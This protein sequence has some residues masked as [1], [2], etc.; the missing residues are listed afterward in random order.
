MLIE[1]GHFGL[2]LALVLALLQVILPS[3]GLIRQNQSLSGMAKPLVWGQFFWLLVAFLV[4]TNAF[5]TNDFSVLYVANNSN[6]NLPIIYQISAV[7]GAHEGS[8]LLWALILATW[9]LAVSLLSKRLPPEVLT[10]VLIIFGIISIGFLSFLIF[11]SNPFER[12]FP[13][14]LQGTELNPLL[15]DFGLAIHPPMLYMGYVG[16]AVP[17]AFVLSA[18]I[19]GRLDSTWL[20]LSM[21]WTLI[22]WMFLTIGIT[23]G[24]WWAYYELGWGGWWFWDPVENASFM[25]WLVATALV[26][27]L[28]V[29]QKRDAFKHW[30]V[31]LAIGGFSLSL[32]GTFLVRS[33]I[34][35]SVHSFA[36]DPA[37]G[38]FILIFL[39]LVVGSSFALYAYRVPLMKSQ[40]KFALLSR[41]SGLLVNNIVLTVAMFTVLLGT[42]Y[43]LL[44]DALSLGKISVGAPYFSSVFIPIMIPGVVL[45]AVTPFL[46]WKADSALRVFGQLKRLWLMIAV[47][48]LL[49]GYWYLDNISVM[50]AGLLFTWVTMHS[51]L[52][53]VQKLKTKQ[54][55]SLSFL[56]MIVA[57]IGIAVFVL[58]A[59]ITTQFGIEKDVKLN[60][61]QQINLADYQFTFDGVSTFSQDNYQGYRGNITVSNHGQLLAKLQPEKRHYAT[62]LPMTEAAI[63]TEQ[64][65]DIYVALGEDLGKGAWS[66]RLY[67]KPFV[68]LIWLGGLLIALG[69]LLGAL[70]RRYYRQTKP[71]ITSKPLEKI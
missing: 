47:V 29:S 15:Q 68:R 18:L 30:T 54:T 26:H 3:M 38:L 65:N 52:L 42:L 2:I 70:D 62:G 35:T 4:L 21:P 32:L 31:L 8:L 56:G 37:R 39:V 27:S 28:L 1:F 48:C 23:L 41:E 61:G 7:W 64:F 45:L 58:G 67:Y 63:Q 6:T 24:S 19:S 40:N 33:G 50:I 22:A 60:Q 12:N 9:T 17:F 57:H 51:L 69:A 20:R 25:P 5:L 43:P 55:I 36:S 34:L 44:L 59:T 71:I 66:V 49:I 13:I 53:L 16:M 46:H 11:T 10:Q 14:P